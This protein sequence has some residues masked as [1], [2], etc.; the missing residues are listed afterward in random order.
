MLNVLLE[1]GATQGSTALE[2]APSLGL[3]LEGVTPNPVGSD[4]TVRFH[5]GGP[6]DAT[7]EVFD[8]LGRRVAVVAEGPFAAGDH[9]VSWSTAG[10]SGG[11]YV[12]RLRVGDTTATR[13]VS[14]MT[15]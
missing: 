1:Y 5:L 4:G 13:T 15:R 8:A 9:Q 12:V 14:V 6:G 7:V 3:V 11:T 10:L 2:D